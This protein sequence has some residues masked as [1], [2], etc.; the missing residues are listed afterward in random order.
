VRLVD[1][2]S[3][4]AIDAW[5]AINDGVMGGVSQGRLRH[6]AASHAVFEGTVSLENNGGF[7]SVRSRPGAF[8]ADRIEA[9]H[10][11]VMGDGKTYKFNL[12]T[13]DAF[14]GVN[15]QAP[16]TTPAGVW[17]TVR[18]PVAAFNPTFRGRSVA[19]A[20]ALAP[21]RV[22]QMGLMIAE[23]QAGPFALALRHIDAQ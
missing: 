7:A 4:A 14:D 13:D 10:L 9:Y 15:Y 22:R 19:D 2:A 18:L 16:F 5:E 20:P 1:F 6:E 23:R 17:T 11:D 21:A 3:P 12:R 8:G